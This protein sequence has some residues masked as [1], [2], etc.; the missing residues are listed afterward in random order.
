MLNKTKY[1]VLILSANIFLCSAEKECELFKLF[2]TKKQDNI[3]NT[4]SNIEIPEIF[5]NTN[6]ETSKD[7]SKLDEDKKKKEVITLKMLL[8]HGLKQKANEEAKESVEGITI[9]NLEIIEKLIKG[10]ES[11]KLPKILKKIVNTES[12][13]KAYKED[14]TFKKLSCVEQ[15]KLVLM[16]WCLQSQI[17]FDFQNETIEQFTAKITYS[18]IKKTLNKK[19]KELIIEEKNTKKETSEENIPEEDSKKWENYNI[20]KIGDNEKNIKDL[21]YYFSKE[22]ILT[23]T[24]ILIH[25]YCALCKDKFGDVFI[26]NGKVETIE[27]KYTQNY[28][29]FNN[30]DENDTI[31]QTRNLFSLN[32]KYIR[33]CN[34]SFEDIT[35]LI[36][37][38]TELPDYSK[39][40]TQCNNESS[41][42]VNDENNEVAAFQ[43]YKKLLDFVTEKKNEKTLEKSKFDASVHFYDI[44]KF[45]DMKIMVNDI[46]KEQTNEDKTED[47]EILYAGT[48]GKLVDKV[49]NTNIEESLKNINI[50][51]NLEKKS[52]NKVLNLSFANCRFI[53]YNVDI[54]KLIEKEKKNEDDYS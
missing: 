15:M 49:V 7:E 32:P 14:E 39:F 47:L 10:F 24:A 46:N 27:Y 45:F 34:I 2:T 9:Q 3:K 40:I 17:E 52:K 51:F 23:S 1:T 30:S 16:F 18:N 36:E 5:Q 35:T 38:L 31:A 4:D 54:N 11:S 44:M 20:F 8:D 33:I 48:F 26:G 53:N 12:L 28:S 50:T 13:I 37:I 29:L 41:N 25:K 43:N 42:E 22:C 21:F 6:N 19:I